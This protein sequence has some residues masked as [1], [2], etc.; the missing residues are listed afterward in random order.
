MGVMSTPPETLSEDDVAR[1]KEVRRN[2]WLAG[3]QGG[4]AGVFGGCASFAALRR[5]GHVRGPNA[6]LAFAM[7]GGA[8]ASFV[9][10]VTAGKNGVQRI[11]DIFRRGAHDWKPDDPLAAP[12]R[13]AYQ[14]ITDDNLK[15][16][17]DR[18]THFHRRKEAIDRMKQ[19]R[20]T[21]QPYDR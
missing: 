3:V 2:V 14:T 21:H 12:A 11:G 17:H 13:S 1:V 20:Q 9:C 15:E 7:G 18:E 10:S 6:L 19:E 8:L 16:I 5:F 4:I